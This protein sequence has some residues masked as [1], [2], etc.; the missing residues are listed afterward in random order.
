M[1]CATVCMVELTFQYWR[2]KGRCTF[3]H[4]EVRG[5]A[6]KLMKKYLHTSL[7]HLVTCSVICHWLL[8]CSSRTAVNMAR[9]ATPLLPALSVPH[10]SG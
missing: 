8:H 7:E 1:L 3:L 4:S 6:F 5:F 2:Q 10:C 9:A